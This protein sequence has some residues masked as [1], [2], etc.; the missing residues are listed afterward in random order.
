MD[1]L[2][3]IILVILIILTIT[4]G[5]LLSFCVM[6]IYKYNNRNSDNNSNNNNS[7]DN[8]VK[9]TVKN[10]YIEEPS[11]NEI[12]RVGG[13]GMNPVGMNPVDMV[14]P[15]I[16][17]DINSLENPLVP[18]TSR[19]PDVIFRSIVNNPLYN[20]PTR[21]VDYINY[22]YEGNLVLENTLLNS[23]NNYTPPKNNIVKLMGKPKYRN[24]DIYDYY[25]LVPQENGTELKIKVQS[26]NKR[27]IYDGDEVKIPELGN[28][29][30][31]FK[32]NKTYHDT[33][34]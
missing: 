12:I 27:E 29:K 1:I 19:P 30:Y 3:F 5:L 33:Y 23:D 22:G 15:V 8:I 32:K 10:A 28:L 34:F 25:V 4:L 16:M 11:M 7:D 26:K 24:S 31:V 14:D 9:K 2:A 18:A 17:H 20:F 21:G 13:V 6:N